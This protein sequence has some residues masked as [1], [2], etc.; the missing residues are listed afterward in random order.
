MT[1]PS[2]LF[3]SHSS[4]DAAAARELRVV[5][6]AAGYVCWLAPDDVVGTDPWAQQILAAIDGCKAMLVLVSGHANASTHVSREV[7]LAS[8]RGRAVIPIRI[9]DVVPRG[10]LEYHLEGLQRVDVFPPRSPPI[11]TS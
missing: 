10:S 11:A 4:A 1:G 9:E 7:S 3:L 6:E 5:L 2:D 8:G